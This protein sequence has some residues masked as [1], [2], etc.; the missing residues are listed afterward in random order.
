MPDLEKENIPFV[1]AFELED[2]SSDDEIAAIGLA[3]WL[4]ISDDIELES[5]RS[6]WARSSRLDSVEARKFIGFR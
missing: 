5:L 4:S 1:P 3:L 2:S 6:I